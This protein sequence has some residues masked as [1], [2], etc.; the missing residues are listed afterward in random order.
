M[1]P[2]K[3]N[4]Y[5]NLRRVYSKAEQIAA[6]INRHPVTVINKLSGKSDFT[7]AEMFLIL[8]DLTRK[9]IIENKQPDIYKLFFTKESDEVYSPEQFQKL[10]SV[11]RNNTNTIGGK[12]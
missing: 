6:I 3:Y 4:Y 2:R 10:L 1:K 11:L 8:D 7:A 12:P 5:P 9:G